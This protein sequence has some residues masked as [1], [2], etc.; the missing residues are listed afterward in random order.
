MEE[1]NLSG[2]QYPDTN[3][4]KKQEDDKRQ[5]GVLKDLERGKKLDTTEKNNK[6]IIGIGKKIFKK[7]KSFFSK[8]N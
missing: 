3:A 2:S 4:Y 6:T 5:E 7:T 8:K 1:F